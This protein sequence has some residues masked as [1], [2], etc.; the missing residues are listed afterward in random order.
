MRHS[1]VRSKTLIS[2]SRQQTIDAKLIR[3]ANEYLAA[4][5][6]W[7]REFCGRSRIVAG[8]ALAG[9]VKFSAKVSRVIGVQY[10]RTGVRA[11]ISIIV[12]RP[13]NSVAVT[14]G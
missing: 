5:D 4:G 8:E 12:D 3:G 6:S 2:C 13:H 11:V 9:V 10:R 14:V 7:H 1:V